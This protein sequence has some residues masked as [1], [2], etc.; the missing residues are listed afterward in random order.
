MTIFSEEQIIALTNKNLAVAKK[1]LSDIPVFCGEEPS[2]AGL[3]GWVF[4]Q[5]IRYCL[6]RE[7][8]AKG[9][10]PKMVEQAPIVGRAKADLAIEHVLVEIKTGGLFGMGD[11]EKYRRYRAAAERK[12]CRYLY[13]TAQENYEPYYKGTLEAIGG[14]NAFFLDRQGA[15]DRF[16][17]TIARE[18]KKKGSAS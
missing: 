4:E 1:N 11:V 2:L 7:L 10:N 15:W 6:Q 18:V 5:T 9:L 16:V 17:R 13:L 14:G 12:G 8:K 3:H